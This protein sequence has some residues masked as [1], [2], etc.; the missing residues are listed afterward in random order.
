MGHTVLETVIEP[1]LPELGCLEA[2]LVLEGRVVSYG[3]L[4][5]DTLLSN[6]VLLLERVYGA[7]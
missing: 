7:H 5:V 6:P 2:D 1:G 4:L 3:N